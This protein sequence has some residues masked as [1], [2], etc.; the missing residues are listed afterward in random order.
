MITIISGGF[1]SLFFL[2]W[3]ISMLIGESPVTNFDVGQFESIIGAAIS[4]AELLFISI[5]IKSI[6]MAERVGKP[7]FIIMAVILRAL[8][9]PIKLVVS[10]WWLFHAYFAILMA[11]HI[12]VDTDILGPDRIILTLL[13]ASAISYLVMLYFILVIGTFAKTEATIQRFWSW[14]GWVAISHGIAVSAYSIANL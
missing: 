6:T 9:F 7:A 10:P 11:V 1:Y 4:V 5:L 12:T 8:P 3:G 13:F 2:L 14:R